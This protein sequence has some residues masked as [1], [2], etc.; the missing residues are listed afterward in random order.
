MALKCYQRSDH[1][2]QPEEHFVVL[3]T[4]LSY[5]IDLNCYIDSDGTNHIT[6]DLDKLTVKEKYSGWD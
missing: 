6:S 1:S 4:T 2:C 3:A 5:P